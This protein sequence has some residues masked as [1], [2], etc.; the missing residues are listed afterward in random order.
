MKVFDSSWRTFAVRAVVLGGVMFGAVFGAVR[1]A[2]ARP[3]VAGGSARSYVTVAGTLTGV[4]GETMVTFEFRRASNPTVLCS[5]QVMITPGMGGTFSAS[6]PLDQPELT[7]TTRCPDDLFDGQDVQVRVVI[8]G[9]PVGTWA[10]INPVPYAHYASVAGQYGAPDCPL[11]YEV[12]RAELMRERRICRKRLR[13]G[14]YDEIVGVG[15]GP[16][17]FWI[18]RYEATVWGES[19]AVNRTNVDARGYLGI[20]PPNGEFVRSDGRNASTLNAWSIA[21]QLPSGN[22]TWFQARELCR[23]SGK[24]LPTNEEWGAAARG[25]PDPGTMGT[26][27]RERPCLTSATALGATGARTPAEGVV[28]C[29][30][31]WGAQDMIGNVWEWT[32]EWYAGAGGTSMR[33]NCSVQN[34]PSDYN[35]D[36]TCNVNG[37]V[38]RGGGNGIG[39]PSAAIRGGSM[40]DGNSAGIFAF[41][42]DSAP[43]AAGPTVGFRC[44][45]PR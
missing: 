17:S 27:R 24:R 35:Q 12:D 11:G 21:G 2:V 22:V 5:P 3:G 4:P 16:A 6:V 1:L 29:Q 41:D 26:D 8:G 13:E 32:A 28:G 39:I 44:V 42:I 18:D 34:W 45:I 30:S 33:V 14:V 40:S 7:G 43:S 37:T 38:N 20:V 19:T 10:P 31:T 15:Y 36:A 23:M 9:N 25:T